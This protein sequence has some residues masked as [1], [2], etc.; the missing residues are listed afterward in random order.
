MGFTQ[1]H[2]HS[3]VG[4]RLDAIGSPGD[5]AQRAMELGHPALA[6]TDHGRI[7]GIWEHQVQCLKYG[8]KPLLG[9]EA[10]VSPKLEVFDEKE[11]RQRTKTQHVILL[12]KDKVGYNNL[13]RLNYISMSDTKH[14]YYSPRITLQELF[15]NKGGLVIGSGCMANPIARHLLSETNGY[16]GEYL[17]EKLYERYVLEFGD[18]FYTEI[19]LNELEE[20]K[21]VNEFMIRMANK[22]GVPIVITGDVH[23]LEPGQDKLQTLAIA[24][25]DKT[26]IDKLK[27]ELE[28]KHL[29]Y[30]DVKDYL[31]FNKK[32]EFNYSENDIISWCNNTMD[33]ADK[34][35]FLIPERN[36]IFLPKM[37]DNDEALLI[38]KG[39]EGLMNRVGATEWKEV[40]KEYQKQLS[41]ELEIIIRKGF[42]SYFLIVED[43]T[44]F[45]IKEKIYGRIGRGSVGGSLLAYALGIHNLDPIKRGLLFER[46]MSES[47]SP[48]LVINYFEE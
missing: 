29:Y 25:R 48:D 2:I 1:L 21:I 6:V 43:I 16:E 8:V 36:K 9:V 45:S 26:T 30:H 33:V 5:Y 38:K 24:I 28:S 18:N 44:Q 42:A 17:A 27:F 32:F 39:K 35:N 47:R 10:Y 15:D 19:Q 13:L 14:F 34:C 7:S 41:K 12:V 11:K 40:P 37:S 22:H 31:E 3:H 4:S 46:F 23:Y 20:Q